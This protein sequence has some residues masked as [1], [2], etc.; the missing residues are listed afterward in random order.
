MVDWAVAGNS[1]GYAS[2]FAIQHSPGVERAE[3]PAPAAVESRINLVLLV[4]QPPAAPPR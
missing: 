4:E 3:R 1:Y 2:R